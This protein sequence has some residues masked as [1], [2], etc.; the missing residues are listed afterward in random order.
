VQTNRR[1]DALKDCTISLFY[2]EIDPRRAY[3]IRETSESSR[4]V[5]AFIDVGSADGFGELSVALL[6]EI[7]LIVENE[8][9]AA[10]CHVVIVYP[11]SEKDIVIRDAAES[12]RA[13][14]A[15]QVHDRLWI[16]S[17]SADRKLIAWAFQHGIDP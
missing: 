17:S 11:Q 8:N 9:G 4:G 7:A 14:C 1:H 12:L 3:K 6:D 15:A 5:F 2:E 13:R 10:K 16:A